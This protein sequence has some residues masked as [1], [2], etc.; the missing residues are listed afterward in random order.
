MAKTS[1]N[2]YY[3]LDAT[4]THSYFK[5]LYKYPQR[6]FPYERL[7]EENHRARQTDRVRIDRYGRFRRGSIL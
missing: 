4:P 1:R 5:M 2:Y 3:Y 6:E 7:V